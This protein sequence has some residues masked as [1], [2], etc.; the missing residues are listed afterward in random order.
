MQK[1]IK[2][3]AILTHDGDFLFTPYGKLSPEESIKSVICCSEYGKLLKHKKTISMRLNV[4][5]TTPSA[6]RK[7]LLSNAM[8]LLSKATD[9][10]I[11]D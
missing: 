3:S 4:P 10:K 2:G 8:E 1:K 5:I 6:V 9:A 11:Q 7:L